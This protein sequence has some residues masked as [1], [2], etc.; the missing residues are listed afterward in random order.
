MAPAL[1]MSVNHSGYQGN[2]LLR[3]DTFECGSS[4]NITTNHYNDWLWLCW[5]CMNY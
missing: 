2:Y 4:D 1:L 3:G 5:S